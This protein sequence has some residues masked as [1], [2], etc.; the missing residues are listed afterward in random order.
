MN[1]EYLA[2]IM[3]GSMMIN[4]KEFDTQAQAIK[5][6]KKQELYMSNTITVERDLG[7]GDYEVLFQ[8]GGE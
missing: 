3:N 6:A 7:C 8:R 2:V 5:W 4:M 1:K